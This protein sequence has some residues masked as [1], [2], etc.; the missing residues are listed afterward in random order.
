VAGQLTMRPSR[1]R[2]GLGKC[3]KIRSSF[4]V[5]Q[6]LQLALGNRPRVVDRTE[7]VLAEHLD[8]GHIGGVAVV[9]DL[10]DHLVD[11]N[12][13]ETLDPFYNVIRRFDKNGRAGLNQVVNFVLISRVRECRTLVG[14]CDRYLKSKYC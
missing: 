6:G 2:L 11:A 4:R 7:D 1:I 12:F 14:R 8:A 10:Q 3:P 9:V 13:L 5:R